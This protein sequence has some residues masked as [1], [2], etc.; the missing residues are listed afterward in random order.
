LFS[1]TFFS[2]VLSALLK[3]APL[4]GASC[5]GHGTQESMLVNAT[6]LQ[7]HLHD[8]DL[9]LLAV[10]KKDEYASGH[11]P[12]SEYLEFGDVHTSAPPSGSSA[13]ILELP[14]PEQV[15]AALV[16]AGVR[17]GFHIILYSTGDNATLTARVYLTLDAMGLGATS[18][19]LDG[20]LTL[21]RSDGRAVTQDV[22]AVVPGNLQLCPQ[23]DV[24]T[25]LGYVRSQ[26][27]RP[28]AVIV[29]ARLPEFYSGEKIPAQRRAG[30]IPGAV[31]VP[32]VSLLDGNGRLLPAETL[33]EKFENAGA[34]RGSQVITYC[35]IGQQ[36]S[37]AYFA[38]R[39]AG[40]DA[41]MFDGSWQEW[42]AHEELPAETSKKEPRQ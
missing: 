29:D 30:H 12:G 25:D 32:F 3:V 7:Q 31:N 16:K 11:I 42:S 35:H 33:R 36:A 34:Y 21:W 8:K 9:V 20:G 6:W 26:V 19:I 14:P 5:G 15:R 41:R 28:G 38:A 23:N 24:V 40:Y 1:R 17:D 39:Y 18:S 37:L 10:G 13:L 4:G 22:P 27:K 2:I